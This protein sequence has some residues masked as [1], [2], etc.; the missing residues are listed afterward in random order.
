M[1]T[2]RRYIDGKLVGAVPPVDLPSSPWRA[3]PAATEERAKPPKPRRRRAGP[4]PSKYGFEKLPV[5]G[6][7]IV[8]YGVVQRH[9]LAT[10]ISVSVANRHKLWPQRFMIKSCPDGVRI[11]RTK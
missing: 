7:V 11:T 10:R 2:S 9:V 5:W 3:A 8:P 4:R 1:I 6:S